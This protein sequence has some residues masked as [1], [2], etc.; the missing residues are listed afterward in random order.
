[1]AMPPLELNSDGTL[2]LPAGRYSAEQ[3]DD[4]LHQLALTRAKM[5][6]SALQPLKKSGEV[7]EVE[8]PTVKM[9]A[10]EGSPRMAMVFGHP[11]FGWIP[12]SF[13]F[14]KAEEFHDYLGRFLGRRAGP[15]SL[16]PGA[17]NRSQ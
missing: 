7:A 5:S 17:P 10:L 14:E 8:D 16:G 11:G 15:L 13:S 3:L 9:A 2:S 1:M 4:L 6:P 12:F